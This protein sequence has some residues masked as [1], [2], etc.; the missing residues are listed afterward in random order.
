MWAAGSRGGM[1]VG[2]HGCR[3]QQGQQAQEALLRPRAQPARFLTGWL[4]GQSPRV[5]SS[6]PLGRGGL[7]QYKY[8]KD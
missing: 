8:T 1:R 3:V 5:S 7:V 4:T 6:P 2:D